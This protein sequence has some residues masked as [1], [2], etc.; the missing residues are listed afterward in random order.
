MIEHPDRL[1]LIVWQID[2]VVEICY[3][4]GDGLACAHF[5]VHINYEPLFIDVIVRLCD[6]V[7]YALFGQIRRINQSQFLGGDT[8]DNSR[9]PDRFPGT[10]FFTLDCE[11]TINTL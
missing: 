7:R 4:I 5:H 8:L 11:K 1:R 10:G 9:S 2:D 3:P 6:L